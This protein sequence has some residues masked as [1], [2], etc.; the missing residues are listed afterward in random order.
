MSRRLPRGITQT[1]AGFRLNLR[2]KGRGLWQKRYPPST[3]LETLEK[4]LAT[5]RLRLKAD[6]GRIATPGT[7]AG[8]VTRYLETYSG[9]GKAE[10]ERHLDLWI[11]AL[12]KTTWRALIT[13]ED[14]AK[15]LADWKTAGLA[16]D[17]CNKRRTALLA[18]YHALDGKGASNPVREVPKFRTPAALPRGLAYAAIERALR[19]LPKCKTRARLRVMAYT[20]IRHG[21]L[22]ALTPADWDHKRHVLTVPGTEKGRGTKPYVLPLSPP[23]QDALKAF[24]AL[25]AWGK[26]AYAPM[27]RMW[28]AAA[29]AAKLPPGTKPYDLRHSFGTAIYRATGDL[30]ITKE[31]M[32]HSSIHVTERY[33]LAAVPERRKSAIVV[34][35]GKGKR[36]AG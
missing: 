32:G 1:A 12:G 26:F 23:A 3:P 19:K 25:E 18:L 31:L 10:R 15:V 28:K 22:M 4:E 27:A 9:P 20:G 30:K 16:A 36:K 5:A 2:I 35:F 17:T 34:T 21:Q 14:I 8:D 11:D 7:L 24:D 6:A 29:A 13:R 33:T